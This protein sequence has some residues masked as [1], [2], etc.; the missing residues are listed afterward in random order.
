VSRW[1]VYAQSIRGDWPVGELGG[2][3]GLTAGNRE[4]VVYAFRVNFDR[5]PRGGDYDVNHGATSERAVATL[6]IGAIHR[7]F[8]W[9]KSAY[10]R[11]VCTAA[12]LL[13]VARRIFL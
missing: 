7:L 1:Q 8:P 9:T 6:G 5:V 3:E 2:V 12:A 4:N 11:R 10:S 13:P